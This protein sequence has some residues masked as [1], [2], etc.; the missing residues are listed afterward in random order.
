MLPVKGYTSRKITFAH[1]AKDGDPGDPGPAGPRDP[2]IPTPRL[3]TDYP[4]DYVFQSGADGE[5][6]IDM[7]LVESGNRLYAYRCRQ[8]HKKRA[9]LPNATGELGVYWSQPDLD[10]FEF[11]A[12]KVLL[13]D[14]AF[15]RLLSS[16]GIR[17]YDASGNIIGAMSGKGSGTGTQIILFIGGMMT[18]YGT[19]IQNPQFAVSAEGVAYFGGLTGQRVEIDPAS[20]EIRFY[21]PSGALCCTHGARTLT[22]ADVPAMSAAAATNAAASSIGL[23]T[24]VQGQSTVT[25]TVSQSSSVQPGKGILRVTVPSY[26]V[27]VKNN[28]VTPV[29]GDSSSEETPQT[30]VSATARVK[31]GGVVRQTVFLG[32]VS[33][34]A[35]LQ[36]GATV[37]GTIAGCQIACAVPASSSW[38][39]EVVFQTSVT[40][41]KGSGGSASATASGTASAQFVVSVNSHNFQKNGYMQAMDSENF[42]YS[43]FDSSGICRMKARGNGLPLLGTP[44]LFKGMLYLQGAG[45][46]QGIYG[47]AQYW[48]S[49]NGID[50]RFTRSGNCFTVDLSPWNQALGVTLG[51]GNIH[52]SI[53]PQGT[54]ACMAAVYMNG[55]K[56][57][58]RLFK[59]DGTAASPVM[60][61]VRIDYFPD[62]ETHRL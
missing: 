13:A 12:T 58:I 20:R 6:R 44:C 54:T 60:A 8:S 42:S 56:L 43:F 27:T 5:E 51:Y 30:T 29:S 18:E 3:W 45:G 37:S 36:G 28:S 33:T 35:D 59:A 2:Y 39:V 49:W 17:I 4:A 1:I 7:V 23:S 19:F 48:M 11:V 62:P 50:P 55:T 46:G 53:T 47:G 31:T 34:G 15:I 61:L 25:R 40:G 57:E 9:S 10:T 52:V 24:T 38:A 22:E 32:E 41:G 21:D 16:N 14:E 26:S